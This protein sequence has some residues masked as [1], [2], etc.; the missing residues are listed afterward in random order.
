MSVSGP[1]AA[2]ILG[3]NVGSLHCHLVRTGRLS[4]VELREEYRFK[5]FKRADVESL[6]ALKSKVKINLT[7][8]VLWEV[9][10]TYF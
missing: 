6:A 1:V 3:I 5:Y 7:F 8:G 9:I 10:V 4:P 2:Q